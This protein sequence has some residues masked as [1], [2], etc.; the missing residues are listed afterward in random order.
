[1][2]SALIPS[3]NGGLPVPNGYTFEWTYL[4]G[5]LV[6]PVANDTIIDDAVDAIAAR[7]NAEATQRMGRLV[8]VVSE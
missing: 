6:L 7:I 5:S 4:D 2:S 8:M 1:M 3:V